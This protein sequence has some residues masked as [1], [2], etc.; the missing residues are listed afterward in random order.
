LSLNE[1]NDLKTIPVSHDFETARRTNFQYFTE[2]LESVLTKEEVDI[3]DLEKI[4]CSLH[5]YI[6]VST[7]RQ[8]SFI[9]ELFDSCWRSLSNHQYCESNLLFVNAPD[10]VVSTFIIDLLLQLPVDS[11]IAFPES[12]VFPGSSTEPPSDYTLDL[13]VN[14]HVWTSTGLWIAAGQIGEIQFLD[15]ELPPLTIQIGFH[16]NTLS[17]R[18]SPLKRWPNVVLTFPVLGSTVRVASPFGGVLYLISQTDASFEVSATFRDFARY[19][20]FLISDPSVLEARKRSAVPWAEVELS[21]V[22]L[23]LPSDRFK[24]LDF[25]ALE[26]FF[27]TVEREIAAFMSNERPI[28]PRL[29]FDVEDSPA[30]GLGGYPLAFLVYSLGDL[31]SASGPNPTMLLMASILSLLNLRDDL[32]GEPVQ[33]GLTALAAAVVLERLFPGFDPEQIPEAHYTPPFPGL[34]TIHRYDPTVV[35]TALAKFQ[36][37]SFEAAPVFE[38]NWVYFVQ[39]LCNVGK[40][41]FTN[42]LDDTRPIP[43]NISS[44]FHHMTSGD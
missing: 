35:P 18:E 40:R 37:Q 10:A 34:W 19:P 21:V 22:I 6:M 42:I 32:F 38:D 29:V 43:L 39:E 7:E 33:D 36:Q 14:P 11:I 23:T 30:H 1:E 41:D 4:T 13:T 17:A 31:L 5:F 3:S 44:A 8:S 20:R 24:N 26:V 15:G 16:Q 12:A 25:E 9:Q 27:K 28:K 2:K